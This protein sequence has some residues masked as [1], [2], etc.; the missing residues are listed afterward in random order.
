MPHKR[1]GRL[2]AVTDSSFLRCLLLLD[3]A[4]PQYRLPRAL[5]LRYQVVHIPQHV[6]NEVV[7]RGRKRSQLQQLVKD[8]PFFK[9]CEVLEPYDAQLLYDRKSNPEA[10]IDRGEAEAIIQARQLGS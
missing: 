8:Y 1:F 7:R 9:K 10:P 2:G 3:F 4:F 5:Q 6:W